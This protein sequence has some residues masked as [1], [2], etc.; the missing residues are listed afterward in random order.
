MGPGGAGVGAGETQSDS[1]APSPNHTALP[2]SLSLHPTLGQGLGG[3]ERH[4]DVAGPCTGPGLARR[5]WAWGHGAGP[6]RSGPALVLAASSPSSQRKAAPLSITRAAGSLPAG[7][8]VRA[9]RQ[10]KPRT[11]HKA[12]RALT[13]R[14]HPRALPPA[15]PDARR[16]RRMGQAPQARTA[17]APRP[18]AC[19]AVSDSASPGTAAHQAPRSMGVSR[20][21]Y[22]S[23]WPFPA[24]GD[25]PNPGFKTRSPS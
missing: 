2:V 25:L 21:E 11:F 17:R 19:S 7:Q 8:L 18:S 23:G 15:G 22:W 24:P 3:C 13:A 12:P 16:A 1:Q 5:A 9:R 14:T 10:E 20:P 4:R 6:Q